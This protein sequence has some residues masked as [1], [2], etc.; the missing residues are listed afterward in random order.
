MRYEPLFIPG[1]GEFEGYP[2]RDSLKYRLHYGLSGVDTI[3]R[4]TLRRVGFC[5]AW[6]C[7]VQLGLTDDSY[8]IEELDSMTYRDFLNSTSGTTRR[9]RSSSSCGRTSSSI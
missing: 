3:Y 7:L 4:G 8:E 2:N 1:Y 6:D 9:C 5:G